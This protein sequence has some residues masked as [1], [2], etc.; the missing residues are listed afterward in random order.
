MAKVLIQTDVTTQI[1][2]AMSFSTDTKAEADICEVLIF[3]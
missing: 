1:C 2:C 3:V